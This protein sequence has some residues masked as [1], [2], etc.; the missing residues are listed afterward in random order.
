MAAG[1][2]LREVLGPSYKKNSQGMVTSQLGAHAQGWHVDSSHLFVGPP[3]QYGSLPCH[4]VTVFVPLF[5]SSIP[6]GPTEMVPG[7]HKVTC[8]LANEE[9]PDQYPT[10]AKAEALIHA[11]GGGTGVLDFHPGD[12]IVMDG[13]VLHRGLANQLRRR[14][15]V[16]CSYMRPWYFEWPRSHSDDRSLFAA[17]PKS[18]L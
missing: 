12:V 11:S 18:S 15:L 1:P 16:Y 5:R 10:A 2:L 14:H 9:V 4:F 13:R 7:S 6:I 3:G 17:R 8:D